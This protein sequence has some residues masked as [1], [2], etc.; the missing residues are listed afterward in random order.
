MDEQ[1]PGPG[2]RWGGVQSGSNLH[3]N[4]PNAMRAGPD[5]G[6]LTM[7]LVR[8]LLTDGLSW[9]DR[10]QITDAI[11]NLIRIHRDMEAERRHLSGAGQQQSAG[12]W[13]P[14]PAGMGEGPGINGSY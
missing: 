6:R 1:K 14:A 4:A 5:L 11:R 2:P 3:F 9:S 10:E 7:P 13:G 12:G 8:L